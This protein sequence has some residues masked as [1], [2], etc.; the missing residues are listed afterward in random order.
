MEII[1]FFRAA[2]ERTKLKPFKILL[3]FYIT[4]L[5][6]TERNLME[7]IKIYLINRISGILVQ[8]SICLFL[9]LTNEQSW[10][11]PP[12]IS[13]TLCSVSLGLPTN[14]TLSKSYRFSC[15]MYAYK[16]STFYVISYILCHF[17]IV[18]INYCFLFDYL[19]NSTQSCQQ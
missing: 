8:F 2:Y 15:F 3:F 14:K 16:P 6:C 17:L 1:I 18:N 11:R 12:R 7:P 13:M 4:L 5:L 10:F 9:V 19:L